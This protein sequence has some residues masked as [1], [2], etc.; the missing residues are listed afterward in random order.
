MAD[1]N[2]HKLVKLQ[3]HD[4][5]PMKNRLIP[6]LALLLTSK[7]L[8]GTSPIPL[9]NAS[10]EANRNPSGNGA[11]GSGDLQDLGLSAP[12]GWSVIATD[13]TAATNNGQEIGFGW[14]NITAADPASGPPAPQAL[15]LMAGAAIGQNTSQAWAGLAE[16]DTIALTIASG[17]RA[18]SVATNSTPRF[19][20][21]SFFGLSEGLAAKSGAVGASGS[22]WLSNVV[23]STTVAEPPTLYKNG[24]MSDVVLT[25]NVTAADLL[26]TGNV[27]IFI[28]SLGTRDGTGTGT[29][30]NSNQSFW[31]HVRLEVI[32]ARPS[33]LF[34]TA[35]PANI[36]AGGTSTLTWEA[37]DATSVSI[38]NGVGAVSPSGS[39]EVAPVT[40]T[41]YTLTATNPAGSATRS[42][43]IDTIPPG[44]WRFYRFVPTAL[45]DAASANS[46]QIAEF[47]L[48]Q[49]GARIAGASAS[50]LGGSSPGGESPDEANDNNLNTKW[51]DFAKFTPLVLDFSTA[52]NAQGYRIA[53]A[54]DAE[55]RDPVSW[56]VEGSH[57]GTVWITLDEQA[58]VAVPATRKTLLEEIPLPSFSG[59]RITF[60]SEPSAIYSGDSATLTWNVTGADA[61]TIS[62]DNG[63]GSVSA[64]GSQSATPASTTTYTI[65]ATSG[66][67]TVSR[68]VTVT[69]EPFPLPG[70]TFNASPRAMLPGG[71]ATLSW[72]VTNAT[73]VSLDG[74][75]GDAGTTGSLEISPATTTT[76]TLTATGRGGTANA[77]ATLT[78]ASGGLTGS[79]FDAQFGDTLL[80]PIAGLIAATPDAT[81]L[82][83]EDLSYNDGT[84]RN[85]LPGLTSD[86]SFS[87]LWTGWFNV[88]VDGPG[89]YT[90]GTE[91]DDG[92]VV[93]LDLSGDGDFDDA[94]ELIVD[95][96]FDHPP[97]TRTGTVNLPQDHLR[98]AIAFY[99]NGGGD[100]MRARFR[101]G[102]GIAFSDMT[103]VNGLTGHFLPMETATGP[104]F[105]I[106]A[107]ALSADRSQ[108][109][110]AWESTPTASYT[111]Q[112]SPSLTLSTWTDVK[113]NIAG[114]GT[115]SVDTVAADTGEKQFFRVKRQ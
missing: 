109:T 45:R 10:F 7:A 41:T 115:Y 26:R 99:E 27:G 60:T 50:A 77:T 29:G 102:G 95:N 94:G 16:G 78:I 12:A 65:S 42:V 105:A 91:S 30:A 110:L 69:V 71:T 2:D 82:Q 76:Y 31:D 114:Q 80:N 104:F 47:Q 11:F 87:V 59:P 40:S 70:I 6:L 9:N 83:A 100:V 17:D 33:I 54:N 5:F 15:S 23:A 28:A 14:L 8:A 107:Y 72:I 46:V 43:S 67:S 36:G 35:T 101:K 84:M 85:L 113:T 79:T 68:S 57:N 93:Y 55:E 74:G 88:S 13:N 38:G 96:N 81:F 37:T 63:I 98:I 53:T 62:I 108:I 73:I 61:G 86:S 19:A 48:M 90:F 64:A 52:V 56:R 89:D 106:T 66:G 1:S 20:D 103:T 24:T 58:D 22:D 75:V 18:A 97:E 112:R 34:F 92:S 3:M 51:L 111:I 49:N 4:S 21:D 32:S 44:P 25:H 39:V